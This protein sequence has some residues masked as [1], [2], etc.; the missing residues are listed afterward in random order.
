MMPRRQVIGSVQGMMIG[1]GSL[2]VVALVCASLAG[3]AW[4]AVAPSAGWEVSSV[5]A[6][7]TFAAA[8]NAGC[9]VGAG[10][11]YPVCDEYEVTATNTGKLQ[12]T[13]EVRFSDVVPAGLVVQE[14]RLF[15]S[16][17][18]NNYGGEN[19][20][21]AGRAVTCEFPEEH[22]E[23]RNKIAAI[24]QTRLAPDATLRLVIFVEV[25]PGAK[26]EG[27]CPAGLPASTGC[28]ANKAVVEGGGAPAAAVTAEPLSRA[29]IVNGP[30]SSFGVSS[31]GFEAFGVNGA[32]DSVAGDHPTGL[33]TTV[34][35]NT[36]F[37]TGPGDSFE[38]GSVQDVRDVVV[39]LPSG[40][41]GSV[42]AAPQCTFAQL[43]SDVFHGVGGCPKDTIVGHLV[44]EPTTVSSL[45]GPIYN[46]VP[47]RG[48]PAEFA[49]VDLIA[50]THVVYSRVVPTPGGYVLQAVSPEVPQTS[51]RT[52]QVQFYGV[53]AEHDESGNQA[54]PFFTNP[55]DCTGAEQAASIYIDS[56]QNPAKLNA[57]G[58]PVDLEE[59]EWAKAQSQ[60]P[61]VVG[62]NALQLSA[63]AQAQP[64]THE[65][66]APSGLNY[67]LKV[68]Q[69][70]KVGTLAT[71][72][73]KKIVTTLPEGLTGDPSSA[74][75][76]QACSETQIG[77]EETA[78]GPMKFNATP[79]ECPE[80]SK[81]GALELESPLTAGT[82]EGEVFL[83]AQ[84]ANPFKSTFAIYVVVHDP[85][86]GILV[87]IAGELQADAHTG[88]L[89]AVFD[90]NPDFPFSNLKLRFFGGPRAQLA[91]PE[92]CAAFTTGTELTPFSLEE[93]EL[94]TNALAGFT[95]SE[96]CPSGFS[97][98]LTAGSESVQAGAYAPFVTSIERSD[99]EQELA[100]LSVT[101]PAGALAK[102]TGVGECTEAEIHQAETGTGGCPASS[103]VGTA[104]TGAGPGPDPFF[105]SGKAYL[106][107]PYNGGS[108]GL[109]VVVPAVAGPYNFG[110]VVVRQSL[111]IDPRTALVTDVSD[112]FPKII[113]GIPL[114]VRRID[115]TIDRPEFTFN[116]TNCSKLATTGSLL[117][118]PQ[119]A[120][121]RLQGAIGYSTLAG[122]AS[123]FSVPFQVG[124]CSTLRFTPKIT[125]QTKGRASKANGQSL[126]FTIS[127]PKGAIGSQSWL[128]ETKLD[129]PKQLPSRLETIQRACT[130]QTFETNRAACP[131]A[132]IIGHAVVHTPVLPEPLEGPLYFVSYG[133]QKFPETVLVL[134]GDNVTIEQHGETFIDHKTGI[135]SA[136]FRNIPDAPIESIEVTVPT[137]R[138]SEFGSNL[139]HNSYNFCGRKLTMPTLF[140][141]QNGV[142]I[143]QTAPITITGCPKHKAK[144]HTKAKKH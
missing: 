98:S 91:T 42:L 78:P 115:L 64:T 127:Y 19:C 134:K 110:T 48:V 66:D 3:S 105:V 4:G 15:W 67:E 97:P 61:P 121:T 1:A 82:L 139:P 69:P 17:S 84:N 77:W 114:R 107:G 94:P 38:A 89:T 143:H 63:E 120:P 95:I 59:P 54:I 131:A 122:A 25:E 103:L 68:P 118:S 93:G 100:G 87:K 106:T 74:G 50:G 119:E 124:G 57:E 14:A 5:A 73:L 47:E 140:K 39:D 58:M 142:E 88:R 13:G 113:D 44:T 41:V 126:H 7:T 35:M 83:A 104:N 16:G 49:F 72:T 86:T 80:A 45:D 27:A 51:V 33:L 130:E 21:T 20:G 102:L 99:T 111:R 28:V 55:T 9:V 30:D 96:A 135:T 85:V 11:Q 40:L 60:A 23:E 34:Y 76:L 116:P 62:C 138:F 136:T 6:P 10:N 52:I 79:P 46:M 56:W 112:P 18:E 29:N 132:S 128:Q 26:F 65:A 70:E 43:S 144:H 133:G 53:P 36:K 101:L 71:P 109:A 117:G 92:K 141:A 32:V 129:I 123:A 90:E 108:Y 81:I 31:F 75:G 24:Y 12:T 22:F 2:I 125:V 37:R 137:G 8:D